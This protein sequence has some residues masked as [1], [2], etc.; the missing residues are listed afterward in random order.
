MLSVLELAK[1]AYDGKPLDM[2]AYL[3]KK[4]LN[5]ASFLETDQEG[6]SPL[7]YITT[8]VTSQIESAEVLES[9]LREHLLQI[10]SLITHNDLASVI[11]TPRNQP[12]SVSDMIV[13]IGSHYQISNPLFQRRTIGLGKK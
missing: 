7:W 1:K 5:L 11:N 12:H 6:R 3:E 8:R 4:P 9:T 10:L 2:L 13:I